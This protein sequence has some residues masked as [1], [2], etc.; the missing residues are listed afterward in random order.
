MHLMSVRIRSVCLSACGSYIGIMKT[1]QGA[2]FPLCL[3]GA[4]STHGGRAGKQAQLAAR[5]AFT[6]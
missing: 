1:R 6:G 3:P 4:A 5:L 2:L